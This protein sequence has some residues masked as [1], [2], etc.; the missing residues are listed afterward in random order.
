MNK[1]VF[2]VNEDNNVQ[3]FEIDL[4][5]FEELKKLLGGFPTI[6][7]TKKICEALGHDTVMIVDDDGFS[8]N[9]KTNLVGSLMY[10]PGV[11]VGPVIFC[12]EITGELFPFY[13]SDVDRIKWQLIKNYGCTDEYYDM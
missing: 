5:N 1:Y 3:E 8:K 9:L 13:K 10:A 4:N 12:R 2:R 11:I 7:R 6:V